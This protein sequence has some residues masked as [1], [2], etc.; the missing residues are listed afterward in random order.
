MTFV[1]FADQNPLEAMLDG[2]A[3]ATGLDGTEIPLW[4]ASIGPSGTCGK[5]VIG[6]RVPPGREIGLEPGEPAGI[7]SAYDRELLFADLSKPDYDGFEIDPD[8]DKREPVADLAIANVLSS[9]L[10]D[11]T[12]AKTGFH[13][14]ALDIDHPVRVRP[15]D[16]PGHYHLFIDVAMPWVDY[17]AVI[18]ALTEAGV[19]EPG[20]FQASEAR[21][22]TNLRLPW[23]HKKTAPEK[24]DILSFQSAA[25]EVV[26]F[27]PEQYEVEFV[28]G[29]GVLR[30]RK[31]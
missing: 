31:A 2:T 22:A 5:E 1:P 16:T 8:D 29:Q 24:V 27:D 17:A 15:S 13:T 23:V 3:D 21:E 7:V 25:E 18:E 26:T 12:G 9:A 14:I 10:I 6:R 11:E 28:D 4:H 30:R 19:V 20:Y